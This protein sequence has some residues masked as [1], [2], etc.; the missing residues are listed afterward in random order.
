M[1]FG[2]ICC[3]TGN[4]AC[5]DFAQTILIL[6]L[7]TWVCAGSEVTICF[8]VT[9]GASA[10][11]EYTGSTTYQGYISNSSGVGWTTLG[12]TFTKI[13]VTGTTS[14][15]TQTFTIPSNFPTGAGYKIA[16][17]S[18]S[19][20]FNATGGAG[21]N[22]AFTVNAQVNPSVTIDPPPSTSGCAGGSIL[23]QATPVNG[24]S[25]PTY[26]WRKDGLDIA[27]ATGSSYSASVAGIYTVQL[28]SN[29]ACA[30]ATTAVSSG[31]TVAI[32][33]LPSVATTTPGSVCG[34]GNAT[35]QATASAG[36]TIDWY[37]AATGGTLLQS[38]NTSFTASIFSNQAYYAEARNTN[39]GC[40]S[41]SRTLVNATVNAL[42]ATPTISTG[43]NPTTFCAGGSVTLT[44]SA[45][46]SYLWSTG[47]TTRSITVSTAGSYTVQVTDANG[48]QSA[49]S[50][51]TVVTVNAL[52][53]TPTISTG[54]NPTTF[55]A[56][57][58]VTL[59]SS[60]SS[61]YLWSTGA[62]TRS[63][64]VSTAG[65]YTVQVT[66]ANGCQSA[67]SA[68]TVVTVNALPATPTISTGGIQ[69][70]FVQVE[71]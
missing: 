27:G 71:V 24:G 28:T 58:S 31:T 32:N 47:A 55:C 25:T 64:T 44:S 69:Q 6:I 8:D 17:G 48:C 50:A 30:T 20:D 34:S 37:S 15:L 10:D 33:P 18:T 7:L 43:G 59:T 61:S 42:P 19:P 65:S 54:G 39:T 2:L 40:I 66:D 26:K 38:G 62:T 16:I 53:A 60:A 11:L 1:D 22:A 56:G 12:P 13:G 46:S 45:S 23:L 21:A 35:V 4:G 36:A 49:I 63:I 70:L 51:A 29:A 57:G 68:A 9:N 3:F 5:D 67:I 14:D 41:S 52:P